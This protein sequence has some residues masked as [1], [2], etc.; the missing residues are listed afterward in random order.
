MNRIMPFM[1]AHGQTPG[2]TQRPKL[3]GAITGVVA[4]FAALPA[5]LVSGAMENLISVL[6]TTLWQGVLLQ[7]AVFAAAGGLYGAVFGRAANDRQG[8]W[9][10]GISYGF[11][12]WMLGAITISHS[13]Q[14]RY[15]ARGDAALGLFTGQLAFGVVLGALFPWIHGVLHRK[16][17][18]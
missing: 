6:G 4:Q 1:R 8:G 10:F 9:L 15:V 7:S 18:D 5:F 14:Q 17:A 16:L 3:A 2:P 13:F 12:L 11:L